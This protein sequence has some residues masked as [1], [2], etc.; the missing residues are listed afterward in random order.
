MFSDRCTIHVNAPPKR[1]H[2][3]ISETL[4]PGG[5]PSL[6]VNF[7][8]DPPR[9]VTLAG[10]DGDGLC[11]HNFLLRG[12]GSGTTVDYTMSFPNMPE[13]QSFGA[14]LSMFFGGKKEMKKRLLQVKTQA[15]GA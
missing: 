5:L 12:D 1:V 13:S 14:R 4:A 6:G 10:G 3:T 9:R 7:E 8:S 2:R 15:E 11:I